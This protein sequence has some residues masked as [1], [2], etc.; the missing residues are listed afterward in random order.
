M[1]VASRDQ[2]WS[3]SNVGFRSHGGTPSLHPFI[4]GFSIM[5]HPAIGIPIFMETS[6]SSQSKFGIE[7]FIFLGGSFQFILSHGHSHKPK[8]GFGP[9]FAM[10]GNYQSVLPGRC[11]ECIGRKK[12]GS[13]G[14]FGDIWSPAKSVK[15]KDLFEFCWIKSTAKV[16]LGRPDSVSNMTFPS[17]M[18]HAMLPSF[19]SSVPSPKDSR[20]LLRGAYWRQTSDASNLPLLQIALLSSE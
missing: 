6:K 5:N 9:G 1:W 10:N 13:F 11:C 8:P 17:R 16:I 2:T 15:L 3:C 18:H 20:S 12:L 14:E 7:T 19:R 4:D